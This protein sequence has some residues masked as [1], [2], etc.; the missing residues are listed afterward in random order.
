LPARRGRWDREASPLGKEAIAVRAVRA[1]HLAS[2]DLYARIASLMRMVA[3]AK[4]NSSSAAGINS[5]LR[6]ISRYIVR[7]ALG[8]RGFV[9]SILNGIGYFL[10]LPANTALKLIRNFRY[11][12]G[13]TNVCT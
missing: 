1:A 10:A 13:G 11:F 2:A 6:I 8:L 7:L 3:V 12:V 4:G 5:L 9:A